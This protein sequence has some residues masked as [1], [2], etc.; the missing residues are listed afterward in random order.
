MESRSIDAG[1]AT[2]GV[3]K[4]WVPV[5]EFAFGEMPSSGSSQRY[6]SSVGVGVVTAVAGVAVAAAVGG[7]I[8]YN[9]GRLPFDLPFAITPKR[10]HSPLSNENWIA[11][12]DSEEGKLLDGGEKIIYKVRAGGVEPAIRAQVWPFL[13]GVYDLDS[14]LAEREVVQFTKHEE[15]E[16][17]RAQCA[18]AAKTLNDQGEEALSDFEQVDGTQAGEKV[19]DEEENF[20]TWRRIIKLDA[21]RMNAEWIPYAA[22]QASVTS[23]EAERL[24]KEA[25]LMDD[26][27]LEPPMR[28]HAARVVLI[29]EA[30]TMYDPETGYCQGMSDLLSPFVALFDKDYEAFWCLVKFMEFARHN[31]RVDEVGIRRQLN[32]VSSIIKTADPEL[33]LHLKSLGCEDCPF[34]YRMVVVLM[35]REL[36][37]EQTLCLWEVMWADWAAIENKKGGGDSQMR[38][39]L[40]PPSRDLLLYTIAAAVRTKRKNIL[41][42]TEKDDLVRECNGMAGHLDIWELLADARELLQLV[43]SKASKDD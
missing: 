18:K 14:N 19:P 12:F 11:S 37:F 27:H 8:Y 33:Y 5:Y 32:M 21:V 42:Y 3:S 16:E 34:V 31:F 2:F 36:S 26:E 7:F 29:L 38:D 6:V 39:K 41:N 40:G 1:G 15:Y 23:Q 30:Y 13:L 20:Q 35:R 25:G 4:S 24:S 10:Y 9:E 17:L 43:R 22:T 28:H